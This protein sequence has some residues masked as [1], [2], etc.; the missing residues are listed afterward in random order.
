MSRL[1]IFIIQLIIQYPF[2]FILL[3]IIYLIRPIIKIR[4]GLLSSW[5]MGHLAHDLE[6]YLAN[7]NFFLTKTI[8]LIANTKDIS[9]N[10]LKKKW[11]EKIKFIPHQIGFPIIRMNRFFLKFFKNLKDHEIVFHAYDGNS[12]V[13]DSKQNIKL[14]DDEIK[15]G[16]KILNKIGIKNNSKIVCLDVRDNAYMSSKYPDKDMTHHDLRNCDIQKFI[17]SVK[18]LNEKGYYVFRMGRLVEKKMNYRDEKYFEYCSSDIQSDFLD[19]FIASICEFVI[20]T[21]TGWAAVATFNFRKPAMYCN[22]HSILELMTH[23]KKFVLSTKIYFSKK[24]KRNLNLIEIMQNYSFIVEDKNKLNEIILKE[25]DENEL[26]SILIEFLDK[27]KMNFNFSTDSEEKKINDKFWK[28]YSEQLEILK[29]KYSHKFVH[30][31]HGKFLS[32]ISTEFIKNNKFLIQ[33]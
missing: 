21:A 3:L 20:S 4:I 18:F 1:L 22:F 25:H 5:R 11:E 24:L 14:S 16:W 6:I 29:T 27:K 10:F 9:N 23:S 2:C 13:E 33:E 19:V 26:L 7:K 17:P 30:K 32:N 15:E 28:I 12:L 31:N 8:D